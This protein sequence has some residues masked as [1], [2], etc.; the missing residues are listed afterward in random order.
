MVA[1]AEMSQV[2]PLLQLND[3][4]KDQVYNAL[5]QAQVDTQDPNWIK[6]NV[7]TNATDPM[8]ILDAQA[9]AKEDALAKVLSPDQLATY[10]Q[11]AQQQLQMQKSMMQKFAAPAAGAATTP[12]PV[13]P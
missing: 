12:A 1:N 10:H 9:K 3:G 4:Q 8:A 6:A 11:Q 2:A 5:Y 13:N 7:G